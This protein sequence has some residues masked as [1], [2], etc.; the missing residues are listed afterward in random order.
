[1]GKALLLDMKNYVI[2]GEYDN[3]VLAEDARDGEQFKDLPKHI[4]DREDWDLTAADLVRFYN[5]HPGVSTPVHR[6]ETRAKGMERLL[7]VL[8][9]EAPLAPELPPTETNEE[10]EL[11]KTKKTKTKKPPAAKKPKAERKPREKRATYE[12]SARVTVTKKA[13]GAKWQKEKLRYKI[14][15]HANRK[16]GISYGAMVKFCVESLKMKEAEASGLLAAMARWD[17]LKINGG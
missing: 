14:Y 2:L 17:L 9:G 12:D 7:R 3:E 16:D 11:M 4:V 6:F 8:N 5:K 10:T 15:E 13:T 1:M